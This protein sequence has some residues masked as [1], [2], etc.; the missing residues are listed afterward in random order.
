[1]YDLYLFRF[2][3]WISVILLKPRYE[4][5]VVAVKETTKINPE[6]LLNSHTKDSSNEIINTISHFTKQTKSV[7]SQKEKTQRIQNRFL[8][9]VT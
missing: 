6:N 1:M 9:F 8:L 7:E 2:R 4:S 5:K 3:D